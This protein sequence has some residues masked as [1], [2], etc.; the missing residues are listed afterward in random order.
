MSSSSLSLSLFFALAAI[1][2]Y[3]LVLCIVIVISLFGLLLHHHLSIHHYHC[4]VIVIGCHCH[5]HHYV[6]WTDDMFLPNHPQTDEIVTDFNGLPV[7]QNLPQLS[8]LYDVSS[9]SDRSQTS[10]VIYTV[11]SQQ[12]LCPSKFPEP[13]G[14]LPTLI[15]TSL[16]STTITLPYYS[17]ALQNYLLICH[18]YLASIID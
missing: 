13:R 1:L 7:R 4:I 17:T 11:N 6:V 10:S 14:Q 8:A 2:I 16:S 3:L 9:G 5:Y 18:Y 15:L 12:I